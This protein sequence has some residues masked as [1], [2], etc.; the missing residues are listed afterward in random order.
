MEMGVVF[1]ECTEQ[2]HKLFASLQAEGFQAA[3]NE[4]YS[5]ALGQMYSPRRHGQAHGLPYLELEMRQDLFSTPERAK[6]TTEAVV[7]A[8]M[9]IIPDPLG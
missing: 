9:S 3:L 7:R 2:A 6:K 4:P 8:I 1:D 5:G